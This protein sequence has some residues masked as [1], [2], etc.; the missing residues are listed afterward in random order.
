MGLPFNV[1]A[2]RMSSVTVL[3]D[4]RVLVEIFFNQ[5]RYREEEVNQAVAWVV[6][7]AADVVLQ[8]FGIVENDQ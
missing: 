8:E 7:A 6:Q 1:T 2:T 5:Q 4:R 3:T